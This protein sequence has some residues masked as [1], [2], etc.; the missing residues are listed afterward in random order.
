MIGERLFSDAS[1]I[2]NGKKQN[3]YGS[4]EDCFEQIADLW[5]NYLCIPGRIINKK[6]V[7]LMMIMLKI[8]REI[9]KHKRDNL[10]DIAGY[11][12]ILDDFYYRSSTYKKGD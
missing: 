9:T 7:A 5:D 8:V 4:P 1:N 12:G 2:I 10:I 6:D 3:E 11:L